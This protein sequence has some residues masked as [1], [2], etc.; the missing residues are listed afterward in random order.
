VAEV[1]EEEA[2]LIGSVNDRQVFYF[3]YIINIQC[4]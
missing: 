4:I 1:E 3:Y 2:T